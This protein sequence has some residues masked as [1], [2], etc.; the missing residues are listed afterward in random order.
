VTIGFSIPPNG[1]DGGKTKMS[2]DGHGYLV[3]GNYSA[4]LLNQIG[5][6]ENSSAAAAIDPGSAIM[7]IGT[8]P[9]VG[10]D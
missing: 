6:S 1:K 2:Y 10:I 4:T 5:S 8:S 9:V 7:P 3:D